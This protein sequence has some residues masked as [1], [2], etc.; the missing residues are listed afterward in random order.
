MSGLKQCIVGSLVF[1]R[2]AARTKQSRS[3]YQVYYDWWAGLGS[4]RA[5]YCKAS[6][7]KRKRLW[8]WSWSQNSTPY[9]FLISAALVIT[10]SICSHYVVGGNVLRITGRDLVSLLLQL[11]MDGWV[12][13]FVGGGL[14]FEFITVLWFPGWWWNVFLINKSHNILVEGEENSCWVYIPHQ[15]LCFNFFSC[16]FDE[17]C[18]WLQK[19]NTQIGR[20]VSCLSSRI[21]WLLLVALPVRYSLITRGI[22]KYLTR[23]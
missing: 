8:C 6:L 10:F 7:T 21:Y 15:I 17:Y 1:C 3:E 22:K 12:D 4:E 2:L 20:I 11:G 5:V 19:N 16:R 18:W 9:K 13:K 23:E 14:G